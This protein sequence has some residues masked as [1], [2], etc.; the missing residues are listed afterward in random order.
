MR[1][2][3]AHEIRVRLGGISRQRV[4]QLTTRNDFPEPVAGLARG[5]IWLADDVEAW[6]V[7]RRGPTE[8]TSIAPRR[9]RRPHPL[10]DSLRAEGPN[11]SICMCQDL[12]MPAG[13]PMAMQC[14]E[15]NVP[16]SVTPGRLHPTC[17][18]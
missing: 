3:G 12:H 10:T 13:V 14:P 5:K 4:Y 8:P 7:N 11:G 16:K 2:M 9:R 17:I 15:M 1:L 18:E 6:I